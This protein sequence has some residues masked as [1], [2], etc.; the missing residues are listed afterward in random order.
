MR[1]YKPGRSRCILAAG[2]ASLLLLGACEDA[3]APDLDVAQVQVVSGDLQEGPVAVLLGTPI[4]LQAS[5]KK[6]KA[7][8]WQPLYF[9]ASHGGSA[10][11]DTTDAEGRAE[12]RWTLGATAGA[13]TLEVL[14]A[15]SA[16]VATLSA[17]AKPGAPAQVSLADGNDQVAAAG[18]ALAKPLMVRV[19]DAHG[20]A[21][22]GVEI[23]FQVQRGG[24]GMSAAKVA[25]NSTGEASAG[26]TL[27]DQSVRQAVA[28]TVPGTPAPILARAS[29]DTTRAIVYVSMPDEATA[30][31]TV[32]AEVR[33]VLDGLPAAE[34]RGLFAA[35]LR[36]DPQAMLVRTRLLAR[37]EQE[38]VA[39]HEPG[40]GALSLVAS[41]A[42]NDVT[43]EVVFRTDFAVTAAAGSTI[44]LRV[45]PSALLGAGTFRDLLKQVTVVGGT[46]RVR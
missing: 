28:I 6:G 2:A 43:R 11:A 31:E 44:I 36:F 42:A 10:P 32:T 23:G 18:A 22:P 27:G 19:L 20:N 15:D 4:Q 5:N 3:T 35:T 17:A 1:W 40:E 13:Q 7:V 46:L 29:V 9:R 38:A 30:G 26:W 45:E 39:F 41:R 24:G 33:V 25:T 14:S 12:V 34:R 8:A 37:D 21:V 16:V